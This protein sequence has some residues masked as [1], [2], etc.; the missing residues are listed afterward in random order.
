MPTT[1]K[2]FKWRCRELKQVFKEHKH[3]L[4]ID[5]SACVVYQG[6]YYREVQNLR[7][8]HGKESI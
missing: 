8:R 3:L 6:R 2:V 7:A 5:S 1:K 4:V